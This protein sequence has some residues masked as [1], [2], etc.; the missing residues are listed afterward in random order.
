MLVLNPVAADVSLPQSWNH[1]PAWLG[2][3]D[4]SNG[5]RN[6]E[7]ANPNVRGE[8]ADTT[9]SRQSDANRDRH[10]DGGFLPKAATPNEDLSRRSRLKEIRR[11]FRVAF[12]W[13]GV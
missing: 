13:R 3:G 2:C 8:R 10:S 7:M 11:N 1:E 12:E 5:W 6:A 9:A 4:E